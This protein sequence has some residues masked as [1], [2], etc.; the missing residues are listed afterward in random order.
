MSKDIVI[1]LIII[2][3][4][5][6]TAALSI[7]AYKIG[8]KLG[9]R[10]GATEEGEQCLGFGPT[11]ELLLLRDL[12]EQEERDKKIA[13]DIKDAIKQEQAEKRIQE[14]EQSR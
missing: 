5:L 8:D 10:R 11:K 12:L 9:Y 1:Y 3:T 13:D 14:Y 7:Y 6:N 4:S 2:G